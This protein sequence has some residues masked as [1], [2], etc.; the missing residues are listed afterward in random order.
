[1]DWTSF[2]LHDS[3]A[4][5]LFHSGLFLVLFSLFLLI[6]AAVF[7]RKSLRDWLIILFS[8][9]F[10]YKS[11]GTFLA[12]LVAS[13]LVNYGFA[14]GL[15]ASRSPIVRKLLLFLGIAVS[16]APLVYFKYFGFL[17][18]NLGLTG[19]AQLAAGLV[20]PIGISFYTFQSIS[21]LVDMHKGLIAPGGLRG[22]LLYMTF[23]PHLV[24]GPIVRGRD[25]LPQ[26]EEPTVLDRRRIREAMWL[27]VKGL[28]KKAIVADFVAQYADVVFSAPDGFHG[29]EHFLAALCY[30]LQI[31]C[32]FSGYTDMAIGVA[33]LLGFRLCR[34]FDSPYK[35]V[36]ITQFW[37]RWHISLSSWLRDYVYIPL[38]G[39]RRGVPLQLGFLLVT[40]L[41][42]G[43]W[44][45]ASW[46]FVFWGAAHGLL[47]VLHK[48]YRMLLPAGIRLPGWAILS[49]LL[50]FACVALLWIPFR[51]DTMADAWTFYAHI[52]TDFDPAYLPVLLAANPLLICFVLGGY[53]AT[54]LPD[55][56]KAVVRRGFD[57]TDLWLK[58]V[59]LAV[60][61]QLVLQMKSAS[62]HPFIYFQ[63]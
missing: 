2:L 13:V 27:I 33:L 12:L 35:S 28:V 23:F 10:Y 22:Y 14:R 21:Y 43:I 58:F 34:N 47:L 44:H 19:A 56:W 60:L 51:A 25:F 7:P 32:D 61:I 8:G 17:C 11:S 24:A 6:Y 40:M 45:G 20:L 5:L 16:L 18:E 38:G 29:A 9:Y 37:R 15:H 50:T 59:L 63:F 31:F 53:A 54:A 30:A 49:R 55:R 4:P 26:I 1:M 42:G 3:K 39:N 57:R 48:L 52:F 62:V 41:V 46:K 36:S